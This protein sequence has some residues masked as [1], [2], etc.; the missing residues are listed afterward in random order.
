MELQEKLVIKTVS[1]SVTDRLRQGIIDGDFKAGEHITIKT[2][3]KRY[4]VSEMPVRE[5]FQC[6]KGE[7][8]LELIQ[9]KGARV[10]SIDVKDAGDIYDIRR[11]LELLILSEVVKKNYDEVFLRELERINGQ[12][13]FSKGK[14]EINCHYQDVNNEFHYFMFSL[15]GN[16]R[17]KDIY[18][19]YSSLF[20]ALKKKYPNEIEDMKAASAEHLEFIDALRAHDERK[21]EVLVNRHAGRAKNALLKK[22]ESELG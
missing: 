5:A 17:A 11:V 12:T 10:L 4:G 16:K 14:E 7:G 20:K 22:M 1:T 19:F 2:I 21:L 8:L 13:D 18:A 15:S 3:V 9:Y 6:L